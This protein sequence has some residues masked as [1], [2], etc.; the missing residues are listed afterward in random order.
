VRHILTEFIQG[1][2]LDDCSPNGIL[3]PRSE[4][5]HAASNAE[6]ANLNM[7]VTRMS[8]SRYIKTR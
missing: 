8:L 2:T 6:N 1:Y 3:A 4:S 5:I 7:L